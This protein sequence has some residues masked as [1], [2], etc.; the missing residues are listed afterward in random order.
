MWYSYKRYLK[1]RDQGL[2]LIYILMERSVLRELV[3]KTGKI[4][5]K[6]GQWRVYYLGFAREGWTQAA[7]TFANEFNATTSEQANWQP[8]AMTLLDLNRVD[9]DLHN[10]RK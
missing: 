3:A 4:L 5:P 7:Q 8:V 2:S 6:Q 10:W 1:Y 9:T